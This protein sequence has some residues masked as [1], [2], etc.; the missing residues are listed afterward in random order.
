MRP[1]MTLEPWEA[2]LKVPRC[3][4]NRLGYHTQFCG[5][6]F[7]WRPP[8]GWCYPPSIVKQKSLIPSFDITISGAAGKR[9]RYVKVGIIAPPDIKVLRSGEM[10]DR[11]VFGIAIKR[12]NRAGSEAKLRVYAVTGVAA[13]RRKK[14]DRLGCALVFQNRS[15]LR[16]S[17]SDPGRLQPTPGQYILQSV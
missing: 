9:G 6:G 15:M 14:P 13:R 1:R 5:I 2:P 11:I 17:R 8:M 4:L 12:A 7:A 3:F 10:V 16:T